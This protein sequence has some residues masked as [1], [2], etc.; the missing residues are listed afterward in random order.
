MKR[1]QSLIFKRLQFWMQFAIDLLTHWPHIQ[2]L[3]YSRLGPRNR[4]KNLSDKAVFF[5]F[6]PIFMNKLNAI[7]YELYFHNTEHTRRS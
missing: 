7:R 5:E 6:S 1:R 3:S 2:T 4:K